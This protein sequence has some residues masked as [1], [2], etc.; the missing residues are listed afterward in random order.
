MMKHR[1]DIVPA[2]SVARNLLLPVLT[3]APNIQHHA[4]T[5][6]FSLLCLPF[7]ISSLSLALFLNLS[8]SLSLNL[9]LILSYS[10]THTLSLSF[11]L[12]SL[13]FSFS[14]FISL[15]PSPTS[16]GW[17]LRLLFS[18]PSFADFILRPG[19]ET[20]SGMIGMEWKFAVVQAIF[21]NYSQLIKGERKEKNKTGGK[22]TGQRDTENAKQRSFLSKATWDG[23]LLSVK[24]GP[25]RGARK[26]TTMATK[27]A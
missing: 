19:S 18:E 11:S 13:S 27:H 5:S 6:P 23:I 25:F 17:G 24:G 22:D 4:S 7:G 2:L 26:Q 10:H 14:L 16:I 15:S 9:S 21:I 8:L 3:N 1:K 12:V 20:E